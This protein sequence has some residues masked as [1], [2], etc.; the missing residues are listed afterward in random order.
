MLEYETAI[1]A[2]AF[3]VMAHDTPGRVA[4]AKKILETADAQRV[5]VHAGDDS[6]PSAA[7]PAAAVA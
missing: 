1:E 2:D 7:E 3:L 5:E 4:L 6:T